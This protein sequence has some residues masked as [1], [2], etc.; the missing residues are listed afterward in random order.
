MHQNL[1]KVL[2]ASR[3]P[4]LI[5]GGICEFISGDGGFRAAIKILEMTHVTT[6]TRRNTKKVRVCAQS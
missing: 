3:V 5:V 4:V 2:L 1:G 6:A